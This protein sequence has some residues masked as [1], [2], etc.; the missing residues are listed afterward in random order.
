MNTV[1]VCAMITACLLSFGLGACNVEPVPLTVEIRNDWDASD[2]FTVQYRDPTTGDGGVLAESM[3]IASSSMKEG[4]GRAYVVPG[5]DVE[6][7][8]TRTEHNDS[9]FWRTVTVPLDA[10][11]H[12][13][14]TFVFHL[15]TDTSHPACP[16][17]R[18]TCVLWSWDG[19][20]EP[21][22]LF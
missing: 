6:F 13:G 15:A 10:Y 4:P 17:G 1:R 20:S 12:D 7:R 16:S 11:A 21:P 19:Q 8:L 22:Q 5:T 9:T 3:P 18:T 2:S 14:A